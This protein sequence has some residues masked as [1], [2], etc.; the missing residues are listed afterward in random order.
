MKAD[1]IGMGF[2]Q[3]FLN[4]SYENRPNRDG[5]HAVKQH[6]KAAMEFSDKPLL[7]GE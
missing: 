6:V 4:V 1:R 2:M 5:F 7:T 3:L